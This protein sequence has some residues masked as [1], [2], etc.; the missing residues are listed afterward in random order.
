[1][2]IKSVF[3]SYLFLPLISAI[4]VVVMAIFNK[5]NRIMSNRRLIVAVLI[6]GLVLGIPG[7]LGALDLNFMPWGFL[8]CQLIYLLLG[9]LAVYLLSK[10]NPD[11]VERQKGMTF[12]MG[13]IACLLGI[14]L[15]QLGFNYFNELRYGYLAA[16]S[17][18]VFMLPLVFWWSYM[19]MIAIP[20][21]IYH[22]WYYPRET[23]HIDMDHLDFDRLKVLEL[24]LYKT[25]EDATPLKVK[26]KAPPNMA[27]G[28]WFKKFID[29]YNQKFPASSIRYAS[30]AEG[31]YGW[32]FYLK[33][34]FFKRKS[35][36]DPGLSI[37]QNEIREKYTIFA[38]R[39][40]T[41]YQEEGGEDRVVLVDG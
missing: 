38:R 19:A 10:H 23:Y 22:V 13:L 28:I 34:S 40:T 18:L 4:M 1:M 3:T 20:S 35:F 6:T 33:P 37:E 15:F 29:D 21:E 5:K 25:A 14:F 32:I 9:A 11:A 24:E 7:L 41:L 39:V 27:F 17:V 12:F 26:V 30:V 2:D 31:S 36:V 8:L 16:T